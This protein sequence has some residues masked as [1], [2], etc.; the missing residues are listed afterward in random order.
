M[1][2][3]KRYV[4]REVYRA[5]LSPTATKH[6]SGAEL[7]ARRRRAGL[8]QR[9]VASRFGV[10]SEVVSNIEA[11]RAKNVATRDSYEVLLD[12][13]EKQIIGD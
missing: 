13:I 1:R 10:R 5:L 3:L 9:D 12:Q 8:R 6:A 11:E 7:A 4:A 2:C